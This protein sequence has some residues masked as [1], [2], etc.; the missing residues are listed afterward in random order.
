MTKE[1]ILE[2]KD[3]KILTSWGH[4]K[5]DIPQIQRAIEVSTYTLYEI[6]PPYKEGKKLTAA[7]AHRKLGN[8]EFLSGIARSA[9]HF[10]SARN[11]LRGKKYGVLFDS[12]K[13]FK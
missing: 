5:E 13:L 9:F 11:C 6:A 2:D 8:K 4:P 3:I 7:E 10:S 1:M 12:S